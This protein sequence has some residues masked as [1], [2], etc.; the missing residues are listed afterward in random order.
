MNRSQ[1]RG[2]RAVARGPV[3]EGTLRR[4]LARLCS[5]WAVAW[6]AAGLLQATASAQSV[7]TFAKATGGYTHCCQVGDG[8]DSGWVGGEGM[9]TAT[10]PNYDAFYFA[11][12]ID[13]ETQYGSM[14]ADHVNYARAGINDVVRAFSNTEVQSA[15]FDRLVVRSDSLP[16]GTPISLE[17]T[18]SLD[19]V[20]SGRPRRPSVACPGSSASTSPTPEPATRPLRS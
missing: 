2:A 5:P 6:L 10:I 11:V 14:Q 4:R 18:M 16:V 7:T 9:S 17:V 19:L 15:S 8:Y 12:A 20:G 13:A 1:E 3:A